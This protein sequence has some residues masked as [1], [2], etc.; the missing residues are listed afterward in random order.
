MLA[1]AKHGGKDAGSV[2]TPW[3]SRPSHNDLLRA[4]AL[5]AMA[6]THDL[7]LLDS[8][9]SYAQPGNARATRMA[10]LQGLVQMASKAKPN[11]AQTKQIV[12]VFTSALEG[13]VE[14]IA[15]HDV[16]SSVMVLGAVRG[17]TGPLA[18]AVLPAVDKISRDASDWRIRNLA[19]TTAESLRAADK[20][21][22]SEE[23]KKL[24]E[25]VERLKK[26][27]TELRQRLQKIE[28]AKPK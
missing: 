22:A 11:K 26:E 25:E 18:S 28:Q 5:R 15:R 7:A 4:A 19:K 20:S 10:S 27:Q 23:V 8:F 24:R 13:D 17:A 1:Y 6:E 14:R 2:L 12:D 9:I 21:G 3:L 16:Q